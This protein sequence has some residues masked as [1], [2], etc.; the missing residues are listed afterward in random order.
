M[1]SPLQIQKYLVEFFGTLFFLY[2]ILSVGHPIAI[3]A[4]LTLSIFIGGKI[5]GGNFNPAVTIMMTMAKKM[6]MVDALP[7]IVAQ[8]LGG[9][10]ALQLYKML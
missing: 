9:L 3:G 2:I 4:A 5:S 1:C 10:V 6:K 7:Y 8:V